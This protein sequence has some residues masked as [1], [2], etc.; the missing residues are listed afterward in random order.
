MTYTIGD[1][2]ITLDADISESDKQLILLHARLFKYCLNHATYRFLVHVKKIIHLYTDIITIYATLLRKIPNYDDVTTMTNRTKLELVRLEDDLNRNFGQYPDF[3]IKRALWED[4]H[5]ET[6][7]KPVAVLVLD[8]CIETFDAVTKTLHCIDLFFNSFNNLKKLLIPFLTNQTIAISRSF[9][10]AHYLFLLSTITDDVTSIHE[11]TPPIVKQLK[12]IEKITSGIER[13]AVILDTAFS[14]FD[15][16]L[17]Q[18]TGILLGRAILKRRVSDHDCQIIH[19]R[20]VCFQAAEHVGSIPLTEELSSSVS[21]SELKRDLFYVV[22]VLIAI[23]VVMLY[24][25]F[26]VAMGW[27]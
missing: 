21:L 18:Y 20:D 4:R 26:G 24:R 12:K 22:L 1:R 15:P 16:S 7:V 25:L 8:L 6:N 2:Q 27:A 3:S 13:E 10:K 23:L 17:Q 5:Y 11:L 14:T 19:R 9:S